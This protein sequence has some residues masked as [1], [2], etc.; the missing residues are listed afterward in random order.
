M[1]IWFLGSVLAVLLLV[2]CVL[3]GAAAIA[4]SKRGYR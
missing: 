1:A 2:G 4:L 3:I